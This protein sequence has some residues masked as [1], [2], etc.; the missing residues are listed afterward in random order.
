[1]TQQVPLGQSSRVSDAVGDD[2]TR[3]IA[4]DLAYRRLVLVNVIFY[5]RPGA[6]DR[7]W[8]LIDTGLMG[9]KILIKSAAAERFG[10]SARPSAIILTHGHFDHVGTLEELAQEWDVPVYAHESERPYLDGSSAYPPGDAAVGGGLMAGL[11]PLYPTKPVDVG[12]RLQ[13]LPSDGTVPNMPGWRWLHTPGHSVGHVSLWRESDRVLIAGDAVV[14]TAPESVYATITQAPEMHG[15]PRYYTVDWDAARASVETLAKLEPEILVAGHGRAMRGSEMRGALHAL[16]R[17]FDRLAVPEKGSYLTQP[18]RAADGSAYRPVGSRRRPIELKP[19]ADQV[20]VITGASS[21]IGLATARMAAKGGAKLVLAARSRD[22]LDALV[23]EI[24]DGGGEAVAVVADVAN[25]E[26][27]ARIATTAIDRFGGFDT[28]INN[29]GAGMYGRLEDIPVAEMR[30][31]FDVNLWGVVYGSLEALKHLKAHGGALINLGSVESHRAVAL[32]GAY[33]ASKAAIRAFTDE[34]RVGVEEEGA[35]VSVTLIKPGAIDTPF[36]VNAKNYL[37]SEPQHVPPVYAA[38]TVADA[39]LHSAAVPTRDLYVGSGGKLQAEMDHFA[40]GLTDK[41]MAKLVTPATE[42]GRPPL[43]SRDG[44]ILDQPS[45]RLTERGNYPGHVAKISFYTKAAEHPMLATAVLAGLGLAIGALVQR[46]PHRS[47]RVTGSVDETV[48]KAL[49]IHLEAR[50]GLEGEVQR[51]LRDVF[52]RVAGEPGTGPW[53]G[54]RYTH[55]TFGIFEA[56]PDEASRQAHLRGEGARIL[57]E[58]ANAL[59]AAPARIDQ[60]DVL[61]SKQAFADRSAAPARAAE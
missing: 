8:V 61:M 53:Y 28:W 23:G 13:D 47:A 3:Q 37:A 51:L 42:S 26:D 49:H 36:P 60:L 21:G 57:M 27:V 56:F 52:A 18:A 40:P 44:S 12:G 15:P 33:A 35:P 10:P 34:F 59:L 31:L 2:G 20:I 19:V 22:A 6:G 39:I 25:Q 55:S 50:R 5:G 29:A 16:A 1:M 4:A 38:E 7:E 17:T 43:R 24:A 58:R 54:V 46:A 30:K 48:A 9:T 11:S 45:E 32:Q 14:T 41:V